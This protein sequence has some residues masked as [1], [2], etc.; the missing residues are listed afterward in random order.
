MSLLSFLYYKN[1]FDNRQIDD[2]RIGYHCNYM[3]VEKPLNFDPFGQIGF[4]PFGLNVIDPLKS[5]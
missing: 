5:W 1:L 3:P 4:V 2:F